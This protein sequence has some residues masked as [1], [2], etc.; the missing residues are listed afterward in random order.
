MKGMSKFSSITIPVLEEHWRRTAFLPHGIVPSLLHKK[1]IQETL[2]VR[3]KP[4]GVVK[5]DE[6][7]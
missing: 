2:A 5:E 4:K 1:G 3:G 6:E 7:N